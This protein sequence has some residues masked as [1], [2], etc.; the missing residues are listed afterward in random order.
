MGMFQ[1]TRP[2][3]ARLVAVLVVLPSEVV[4]IHAPTRGA[5]LYLS[6]LIASIWFQSTRP[7]GARL[8][9]G[10]VIDGDAFVSIHA[11]TRGATLLRLLRKQMME[12][13]IHAPTRG[14]TRLNSPT[15][16]IP[17]SFNP[18]AHAGRDHMRAIRRYLK[19]EFQSTRPRGA[20][21]NLGVTVNLDFLFQ[22]TRP[23]GARRVELLNKAF[24][25]LVSIHAPTR[26]A[27][28]CW[29]HTRIHQ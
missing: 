9:Q 10:K 14:A 29:L 20:R 15:A 18:R 6:R 1:S 22:S 3:G 19:E 12:V 4:S 16:S 11:P 27:T 7:R 2:R 13:S 28:E 26:G 17:R 24:D 23:R 21:P 8:L 25:H 5:T